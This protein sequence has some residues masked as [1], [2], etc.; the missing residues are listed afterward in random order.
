M[1][2]HVLSDV[3][4]DLSGEIAVPDVDADVVILAGDVDGGFDSLRWAMRTFKQPVLFV[5]GNHEIVAG[6]A[7]KLARFR[8]LAVGSNVTLL[9]NNIWEHRGVRFLGCT[10]WAPATQ[11]MHVALKNSI[12]WLREMLAQPCAGPTV[13]VTHYAPLHQSLP[14]EILIDD[15]AA[16]RLTVD[17]REL[18]EPSNIALW[19]HG[20]I[21]VRQD[22]YCGRTRVVCNPR[23]YADDVEP[24]FDPGYVVEVGHTFSSR[25][26]GPH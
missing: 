20:H 26:T 14:R 16:K 1:R 22:Y 8:A 13:V 10:L 17:L 2:L 23:G 18:I 12:A 25:S 3:H 21:H 4:R 7:E 19:V 5:L 6:N 11:R 9:E 24:R 15:A